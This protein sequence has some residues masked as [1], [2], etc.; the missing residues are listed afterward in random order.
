MRMST[1]AFE[2]RQTAGKALAEKLQPYIGNNTLLLALPRGGVPVAFEIAN[3][4]NLPLD[5]VVVR[6]LGAPL[7]PEYGFGAIAPGDV[8]I[9]DQATV[10][11]LD[12]SKEVI[13]VVMKKELQ[14]MDRRMVHY[15]S[16]EWTKGMVAETVIVIDDGLA[17]G[18]SARAALESVRLL[19]KPKKLIFASPV[20]A[21]DSLE[22][23]K[24]PAD[25][26]VCVAQPYSLGAI[27]EWYRS[28]EQ[29]TD[30]EVLSLLERTHKIHT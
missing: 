14:E 9:V 25:E 12:L 6:K 11:F 30:E 5:I 13:E 16:G 26:I 18:A 2:D 29:V 1:L 22:K 28:F 17:T 19:Y 21:A 3:L 15:R 23:V 7:N 27:G 10:T 20:C 8:V 24:P 4:Y